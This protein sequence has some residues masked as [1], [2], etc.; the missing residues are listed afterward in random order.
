MVHINIS[1]AGSR[2]KGLHGALLL[3]PNSGKQR[4]RE[5]VYG[6]VVKAVRQHKWEVKL[7]FDGVAK[8]VTSKLLHLAEE[9]AG[10]PVNELRSSKANQVGSQQQQES[11][12]FNYY[13]LTL[14]FSFFIRVQP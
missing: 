7:D 8:E 5:R 4:V 11:Y 12:F 9:G 1:Y 2:V 14:M 10:I 3:N 13:L 6:T